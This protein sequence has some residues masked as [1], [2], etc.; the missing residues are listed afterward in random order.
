MRRLSTIVVVLVLG[1]FSLTARA[2]DVP[3]QRDGGKSVPRVLTL[4]PVPLDEDERALVAAGSGTRSAGPMGEVVYE[5]LRLGNFTPR[6]G[7]VD[8]AP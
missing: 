8:W 4:T 1:A 5:Q 6:T 2:H 3:Q 7:L